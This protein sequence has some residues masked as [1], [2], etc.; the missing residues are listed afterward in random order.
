MQ[1]IATAESHCKHSGKRELQVQ[2]ASGDLRDHGYSHGDCGGIRQGM[3]VERHLA[4]AGR[5]LARG[6]V[7]LA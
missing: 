3:A 5:E 2:N 6:Y 4:D 1:A 7:T